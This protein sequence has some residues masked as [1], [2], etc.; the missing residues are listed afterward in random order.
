[1]TLQRTREVTDALQN[2]HI[3]QIPAFQARELLSFQFL[4]QVLSFLTGM[5]GR[6]DDGVHLN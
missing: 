1:M 2:M 5:E 6:R 3:A 4:A